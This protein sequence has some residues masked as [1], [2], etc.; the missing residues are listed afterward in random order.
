MRS[1]RGKMRRSAIIFVGRPRPSP[2]ALYL[3]SDRRLI[4]RLGLFD[5]QGWRWDKRDL[6]VIHFRMDPWRPVGP[7]QKPIGLFV[8]L[9]LSRCRVPL[10][11]AAEFHRDV[12]KDAA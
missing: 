7:P 5:E 12:G 2:A 10:Q 4:L 6:Y 9:N 3:T 1:T 11:R 8:T